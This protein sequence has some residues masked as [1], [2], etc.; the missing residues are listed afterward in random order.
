MVTLF[1]HLLFHHL[2]FGL[3]KLSKSV[4]LAAS[5]STIA[6]L[7]FTAGLSSQYY[8]KLPDVIE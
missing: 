3:L 5:K 2:L 6:P 4:T 7:L 8:H 1:Q